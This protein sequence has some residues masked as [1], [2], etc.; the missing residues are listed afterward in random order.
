MV[1]TVNVR[2]L[3]VGLKYRKHSVD[4]IWR[5]I[6]SLCNKGYNLD[7]PIVVT[8]I[9]DFWPEVID[10]HLRLLALQWLQEY[11]EATYKRI[12]PRGVP[13]VSMTTVQPG[14]LRFPEFFLPSNCR[15]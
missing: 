14:G 3:L 11:H 12:L 13:I 8:N 7:K 5:M 4:A 15:Q 10:G 6:R 2:C 9:N 1:C